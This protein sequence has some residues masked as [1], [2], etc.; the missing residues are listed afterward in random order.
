MI[1]RWVWVMVVSAAVSTARADD[2]CVPTGSPVWAAAVDGV[3]AACARDDTGEHCIAV[4]PGGPAKRA[5]AA[6]AKPLPL[7]AAQVRADQACNG[8]TCKKL[9]P[10]L[11]EA[12][13][14]KPDGDERKPDP[15]VTD[16]LAV[17]LL[18]GEAWSV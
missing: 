17:V 9:G 15:E 12:L 1:S 8:A 18:G 4:P 14:Q 11:V 3:G 6:P 2:A 16:D 5:T 10:K 7:T 13:H